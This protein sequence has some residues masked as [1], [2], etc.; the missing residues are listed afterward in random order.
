[1]G[2][3]SRFHPR[4]TPCVDMQ[5]QETDAGYLPLPFPLSLKLPIS[6]QLNGQEAS[7]VHLHMYVHMHTRCPQDCMLLHSVLH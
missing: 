1:M 2:S 5:K 6:A 3:A 4:C 7:R